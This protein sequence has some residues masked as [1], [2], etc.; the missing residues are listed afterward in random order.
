MDEG[1]EPAGLKWTGHALVDV[2]VAMLT[3]HAGR[4]RPED[5]STQDID[6]FATDAEHLYMT[7]LLQSYLTVLFTANGP[8]TQPSYDMARRLEEARRLLRL[9]RTEG[10]P[11]ADACAFCGRPAIE[12]LHREMMPLTSAQGPGNFFPYGR[13]G[14]PACG[15]CVVSLHALGIGAP[16]CSGRALV[17]EAEDPRF[18]LEITKRWYPEMLRLAHLSQATQKKVAAFSHPLTRTIEALVHLQEGM[19]EEDIERHTPVRAGL[20]VY[21]LSNSGQRPDIHIR[22]LPSP[23]V[24]FVWR[25]G[26]PR[27]ELA[28]QEIVRRHWRTSQTGDEQ[29]HRRNDVYDAL[30]TLPEQA[31]RFIRRFMLPPAVQQARNGR[32]ETQPGDL[33]DRGED[34][35]NLAQLFLR[36]VM[37]MDEERIATIRKL[38]DVL[39]DE[40]VV[41]NDAQLAGRVLRAD[42]YRN[43]RA[44]LIRT[45]I[46]R[47][48][49]GN[50]PV[51]TLDE[52]LKVFEEGDEVRRSDWRLAWD[53]T[54]IRFIEILGKREWFARQTETA[55]GLEESDG[56]GQPT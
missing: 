33:A 40:V 30:F 54:C 51:T 11:E 55:M 36:E 14:V 7:P 18:L 50:D 39:A 45:S 38:G 20:T 15:L 53:L 43:V 13:S 24:R 6:S 12:R 29:I 52:F 44:L 22:R 25:A 4:E 31:S 16:S 23:I 2:G 37:G 27:Y 8:I 1:T 32:E 48:R 35:W 34:R 42:D 21:H 5:V 47:V 56:D 3:C 26:L 46:R 19:S 49:S 10:R 17:V 41:S 9:H 28:W